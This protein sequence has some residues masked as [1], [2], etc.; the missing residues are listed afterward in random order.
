MLFNKSLSDDLLTAFVKQTLSHFFCS[1]APLN[2]L[3]MCSYWLIWSLQSQ[4]Q[5]YYPLDVIRIEALIFRRMCI[6]PRKIL[7]P[8]LVCRI[9]IFHCW[10]I[11]D[12]QLNAMFVPLIGNLRTLV[13]ATWI[14]YHSMIASHLVWSHAQ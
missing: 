4:T 5:H 10:M 13:L 3:K 1:Q 12:D 6:H 9:V 2:S 14:G 8:L 11:L 7:K